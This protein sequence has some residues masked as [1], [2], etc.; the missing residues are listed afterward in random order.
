MILLFRSGTVKEKASLIY[1]ATRTHAQN[2]AKYATVYKLT[3]LMLK[4]MGNNPGKEGPYDTFFAGLLGGYLVFGRR[5]KK[6]HV[7]SVSKQ[8]VIF[9]RQTICSQQIDWL[10]E[11]L[12]V[13]KSYTLISQTVYRACGGDYKE[14]RI[15]ETNITRCLASIRSY[16]L[17][18]CHV[19]LQMV[20][21]NRPTRIKK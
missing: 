7:S 21:R 19:A 6:G 11:L 1:K 8:I 3:M 9:G 2:L 16:E 10:I 5:S 18:K 14:P 13:C 20:P 4:H 17:G 15:N 12:S